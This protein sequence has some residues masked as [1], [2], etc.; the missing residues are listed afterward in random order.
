MIHKLILNLGNYYSDQNSDKIP[1]PSLGL[2]RILI[3]WVMSV[4]KIFATP[5]PSD[6]VRKKKLALFIKQDII[7]ILF[8]LKKTYGSGILQKFVKW[9]IGIQISVQIS[10]PGE[11]RLE[12]RMAFTSLHVFSTLMAINLILIQIDDGKE[13]QTLWIVKLSEIQGILYNSI[14]QLI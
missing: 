7:E 5:L 2:F 10:L 4:N 12:V 14:G 6:F 3:F 8:S 9:P 13:I 1:L 11:N